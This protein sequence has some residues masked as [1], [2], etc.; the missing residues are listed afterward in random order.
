MAASLP[1][2]TPEMDAKLKSAATHVRDIVAHAEGF[3]RGY[4]LRAVVPPTAVARG[5]ENGLLKGFPKGFYKGWGLQE[6]RIQ[7]FGVYP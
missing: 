7:G 3:L 4:E 6:I 2:L 1:G 5:Q